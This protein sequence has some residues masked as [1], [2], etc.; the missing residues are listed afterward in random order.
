VK[1]N[2]VSLAEYGEFS[3]IDRISKILPKIHNPNL[4]VD[5]GDDTAV[6][7]IDEQRA[8]L[9]TC[10]IQIEHQHFRLDYMTPYQVGRR[11]MA[12]NLSDIAAMGGTPVYALV[13]L[14]LPK[15]LSIEEYDALFEGMRDELYPHQAAIV[16][17]NLAQSADRLIV[18]ITLI[19]EVHLPHFL[20]RGGARVGDRVFV[21]GKLGA[22][23]AGFQVL[24]KQGKS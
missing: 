16:G 22:S 13:S 19:G 14:G 5:I 18:D 24:Q 3:L 7:K 11:A 8:W 10:D 2:T 1:K 4:L 23:G 17:G 6:I 21:S 12:V 20:T 9:L 15:S